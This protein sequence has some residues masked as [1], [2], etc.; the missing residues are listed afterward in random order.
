MQNKSIA[1]NFILLTTACTLGFGCGDD[2][3]NATST[4]SNTGS[5]TG[6]DTDTDTDT[7]SAG[8]SGTPS[9]GQA[10]DTSADTDAGTSTAGETDSATD[11]VADTDT[12]AATDTDTAT[13]TESAELLEIIGEWD[14]NFGEVQTIDETSWLV[15]GPD[16]ESTTIIFDFDNEAQWLVGDDS[17]TEGAFTRTDWIWVGEQVWY[18]SHAFAVASQE[19]AAA[20]EPDPPLDAADQANGCEGFAWTVLTPTPR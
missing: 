17:F 1:Y 12:D 2:D 10:T 13:D 9:T 16:Y 14:S 5:S 8:I 3:G 7:T 18:C 20:T 6:A 4:A 15:V 11:T 19:E